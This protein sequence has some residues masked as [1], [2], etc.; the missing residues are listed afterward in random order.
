MTKLG[1]ARVDSGKP[2]TGVFEIGQEIPLGE[3]I[4]DLMLSDVQSRRRIC[5]SSPLPSLPMK[6]L[7]SRPDCRIAMEA[8]P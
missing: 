1:Y 6:H 7:V 4:A 3:A 2:M 5:Q 8:N